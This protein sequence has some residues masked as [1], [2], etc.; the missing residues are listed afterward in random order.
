MNTVTAILESNAD[1]SVLLPLASDLG[2]RKVRVVVA[3]E[4]VEESAGHSESPL[5]GLKRIAARGGLSHKQDP[6][7][8]QNEIREER[9]LPGRE[10]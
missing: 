6:L 5:A 2:K 7:E 4:I 3:Y 8:W 10:Q 9:R 1:G